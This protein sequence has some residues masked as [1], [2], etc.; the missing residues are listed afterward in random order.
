MLRRAS[1]EVAELSYTSPHGVLSCLWGKT[2]GTLNIRLLKRTIEKNFLS[3]ELSQSTSSQNWKDSSWKRLWQLGDESAS[4]RTVI[5]SDAGGTVWKT[6]PAMRA[7]EPCNVH[8][9]EWKFLTLRYN[10][11]NA[12]LLMTP[13]IVP[14]LAWGS[15]QLTIWL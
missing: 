12:V 4:P 11:P 3:H 5:G 13:Q 7:S 9:E 2:A 6:S 8:S 1:L 14:T 15:S 10:L